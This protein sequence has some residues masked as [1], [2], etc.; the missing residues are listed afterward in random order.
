MAFKK[1][2]TPSSL[3]SREPAKK[4]GAFAVGTDFR[5]GTCAEAARDGELLILAVKGTA[6]E[7]ALGIAGAEVLRGKTIID[8]TNPIADAPPQDGVLQFFTGTN[9][10]G[11]ER[12]QSR[13]PEAHFVKAFNCVGNGMMYQPRISDGAAP[14]MF[15][16]GDDDSA[17]AEVA[18][19]LSAF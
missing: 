14:T 1:K 11:M 18:A 12:L 9:D 19:V 8:V 3:G 6:A 4:L 2:A 13:F 17:K 7:E 16:C 10:S 5:I 15:Y